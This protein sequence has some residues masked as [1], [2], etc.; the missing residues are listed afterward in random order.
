[1]NF[2]KRVFK[3]EESASQK[4]SFLNP[5]STLGELDL[6]LIGEGR[7]EEL[8]KV[9]G[10]HIKREKS[11]ELVGTA[12]SVWAPNARAVSLITDL[13]YCRPLF[14]RLLKAPIR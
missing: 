7:H 13:N 12:F 5:N 11:G 10:A 14:S 8:W 4:V 1:M 2:L 3:S 6:Y 9:L